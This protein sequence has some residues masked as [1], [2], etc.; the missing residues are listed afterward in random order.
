MIPFSDFVKKTREELEVSDS[1]YSQKEI[2]ELLNSIETNAQDA[3]LS[4]DTSKKEKKNAV[5]TI[6]WIRT[7][8]PRFDTGG[9]LPPD[10]MKKLMQLRKEIF[11]TE[12]LF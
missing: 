7:I 9:T 12:E 10:A 5:D 11:K 8:R 4:D 6:R 3:L 1:G 2:E